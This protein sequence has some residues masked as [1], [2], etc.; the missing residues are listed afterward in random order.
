[1]CLSVVS[2]QGASVTGCH[3]AWCN[4]MCDVRCRD[5]DSSV[6]AGP[7]NWFNT[8]TTLQLSTAGPPGGWQS[9]ATFPLCWCW[10]QQSASVETEH[11]PPSPAPTPG[12]FVRE[13]RQRP[14]LA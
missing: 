3:Y 6:G 5:P 8:H 10:V 7:V 2:R 4:I 11:W 13:Q 12:S 14:A 9:L 1:M